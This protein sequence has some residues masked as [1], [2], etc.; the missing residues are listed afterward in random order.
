MVDAQV[1]IIYPTLRAL[2]TKRYRNARLHAVL[3]R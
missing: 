3:T 2:R 1:P